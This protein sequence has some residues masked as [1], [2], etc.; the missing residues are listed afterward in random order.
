MGVEMKYLEA[1]LVFVPNLLLQ[2]LDGMNK[3]ISDLL[4]L[5]K[6][7]Q[8]FGI[9][10]VASF[11]NLS[12]LYN[13]KDSENLLNTCIAS[14]QSFDWFGAPMH[15]L[16]QE[17]PELALQLTRLIEGQKLSGKEISE[18]FVYGVKHSLF[19]DMDENTADPVQLYVPEIFVILG[20]VYG[21]RLKA[22]TGNLEDGQRE[23]VYRNAL[24]ATIGQLSKVFDIKLVAK[25]EMFKTFISASKMLG[26]V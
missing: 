10:T 11:V 6:M 21:V 22:V 23:T 17:N 19:N 13:R 26:T 2:H 24:V 3:P 1:Q 14:F 5:E 18:D 8:S 15:K 16:R 7:I 20:R 4:D 9:E 12:D 25:T